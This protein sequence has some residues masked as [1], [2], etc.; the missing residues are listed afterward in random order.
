MPAAVFS[1]LEPL[2]DDK[3]TASDRHDPEESPHRGVAADGATETRLM[4][5]VVL[6]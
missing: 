2:P 3:W 4:Y 6:T 5:T 1:Q